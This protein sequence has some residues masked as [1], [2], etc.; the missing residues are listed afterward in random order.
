MNSRFVGKSGSSNLRVGNSCFQD[1]PRF[2]GHL[3][4]CAIMRREVSDDEEEAIQSIQSG[5]QARSFE[6]GRIAHGV[7]SLKSVV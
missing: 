3:K 4:M 7:R 6:V 5:V 2:S 1:L